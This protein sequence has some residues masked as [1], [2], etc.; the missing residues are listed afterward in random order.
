MVLKGANGFQWFSKQIVI[1]VKLIM[2]YSNM[3]ISGERD[4]SEIHSPLRHIIVK[5]RT[6]VLCLSS[7]MTTNLAYVLH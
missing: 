5:S 6:R 3:K 1:P 2:I 7:R 4:I